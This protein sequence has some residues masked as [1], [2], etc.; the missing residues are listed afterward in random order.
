MFIALIASPIYLDLC[1]W[2][3]R[4]CLPYTN[5]QTLL[6]F[7]RLYVTQ[8]KLTIKS[9]VQLKMLTINVLYGIVF[10]VIAVVRLL[11]FLLIWQ[12]WMNLNCAWVGRPGRLNGST[13]IRCSL[14]HFDSIYGFIVMGRKMEQ[15]G[16]SWCVDMLNQLIVSW[17][18]DFIK[19]AR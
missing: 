11:V 19:V 4:V 12:K 6:A 7:C 9:C 10:I 2:C 13:N 8:C 15:I 18:W 17:E 1:I 3:V 5:I 16:E 14:C